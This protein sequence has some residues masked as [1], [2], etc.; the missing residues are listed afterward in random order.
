[1]NSGDHLKVAMSDTPQ[2]LRVVLNDVTSGKS[3]SMTASASNGFAQIQFD[4]TG[5]SCNAIPYNFHPMYSTASEQTR[6]IWAA[7]T[8]N[9]A[10]SDE[11]GHFEYCSGP[12]P[13]PSTPFGVD[14]KGNPISC[15][16]GNFE[17]SAATRDDAEAKATT[18]EPTDGDDNFCFPASQALLVKI[19]GCTDTNTGFDG[20]DYQPV[21]PD[22]NTQLHPTPILF[23]SPLTGRHFDVNYTRTAF[24][25]DL[26][27][28]EPASVC[29][30]TTGVGCTLTPSTDDNQPVAFY[31]FFSTVQQEENCLW[32][33]G[34]D[35][36][37]GTND[38]G[39]VAQYGTPLK[40]SVLI[41]G[42]GGAARIRVAN[43]R[44]ILSANPCRQ[45]GHE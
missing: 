42:G 23:S 21:W 25:A 20:L 8:Y 29:N 44:Q 18:K 38:F 22:G 45:S 16:A 24:E 12:K 11:I 5:T 7:H 1:M 26:P 30:H 17:E 27:A 28:I 36:P 34:N 43:F 32:A 33:F 4:P 6:V 31:P 35:L 41:F 15:P 37:G 14:S 39:R 13:I 2:G 3:G 9:I 40:Q 19:S 10:F